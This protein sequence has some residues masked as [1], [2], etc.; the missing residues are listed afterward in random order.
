MFVLSI[1][2]QILSSFLTCN[3][4]VHNVIIL[5]HECVFYGVSVTYGNKGSGLEEEGSTVGN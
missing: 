3:F 4:L 2:L 5:M 1:P